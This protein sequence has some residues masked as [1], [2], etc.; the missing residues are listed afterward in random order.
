VGQRDVGS[1]ADFRRRVADLESG[2]TVMVLVRSADGQT[3]FVTLTVG[4]D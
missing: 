1:A 2:D 3:R 4:A